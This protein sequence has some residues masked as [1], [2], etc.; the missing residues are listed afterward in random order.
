MKL[1]ETIEADEGADDLTA[2]L[3]ATTNSPARFVELA[4]PDITPEKW[5]RQV[6]ETIGNQLQE[7]AQLD[8]WKAVQVAICSGNGTGK[9]TLMS[10][11]ILWSLMT[12]EQT[13]GVATAGS[14]SQLR[15]RLWG[16]LNRWYMQLPEGLRNQFTMTA[17]C[18]FA[19]DAERTWRVDARAWSAQNQESFSGLHN[20]ERRV[21]VVMDEASMIGDNIFRACSGMLSDAR[22]QTIW[23]LCGNP[24]RLTG[25]FYQCFGAGRFSRMW[26]QFQVDSRSVSITNKEALQEKI[27]FYGPDSNYAKSH[28]YGQ[29]PSATATSLIPLDVVQQA[30]TRETFQHP[31]DAVVIGVDVSSGH[32]EDSSVIIVRRGLDA[33]SYPIWRSSTTDPI[34][35]AYQVAQIANEVS[36]DAVFVDQTGLGEGSVS[37]L[38]ELG[39]AVH[40]VFAAGKSSNA[41]TVRCG[42][43]RAECWTMM[44]EW[45]RAGAIPR[46]ELL[47]AELTAPEFS[48][49]PLGL[50]I[51]K[52]EH[53][54]ERGLSS[55]D[56]ADAL[57]LTF[58]SPIWSQHSDLPGPGNHLVQSEYDPYSDSVM[59]GEP[60]PELKRKYTAPGYS[61][62]PEWTHEGGWNRQDFDDAAA[63][64]ALKLV[65][66]EPP[67]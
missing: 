35:L 66:Q 67:D 18:L 45:L 50:L 33:R 47:M 12:F 11:V 30:A 29:F 57:S 42:N 19:R 44:A 49:G 59:R 62:K 27:G 13:L 61:L 36:A 32:S 55:P 22:T 51:E 63:S 24:I 37:R 21:L 60:I 3:L 20:F 53:M 65:W 56:S 15:V 25:Y 40:G 26:T 64:D 16:E 8:R 39:V 5:Q 41:G 52:K 31:T 1:G 34:Q 46:D 48:E 7:N 54:R 23:L 43:K 14:E 6:L 17:T 2:E 58:A 4:F 28:I 9:S 10:W 38:R